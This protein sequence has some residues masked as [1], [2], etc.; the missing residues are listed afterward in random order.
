[1]PAFANI[2]GQRFGRWLVLNRSGSMF[3]P[4]GTSQP[5]YLCLCD[6]GN[7]KIV[8]ASTLKDGS[9]KSCG[10]LNAETR[11]ALCIQRNTTHGYAA[12]GKS[13]TYITWQNMLS[14]CRN[15]KSSG[16]Y[17]YGAKGITVSDEWNAFETFL[18]DMGECPP[19]YSIERKN[20]F[21]GYSKK[22]CTWIPLSDQQKNKTNSSIT[23]RADLDRLIAMYEEAHPKSA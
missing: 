13:K 11:K 17:K 22:N 3:Y 16:Y 21:L 8:V 1:M 14:R 18:A 4:S 20:P 23:C 10:C 19:G 12:N 15:P 6:C 9:S 7:E 2:S 5:Q